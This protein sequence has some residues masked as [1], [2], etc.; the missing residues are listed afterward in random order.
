[1]IRKNTFPTGTAFKTFSDYNYAA[2]PIA[3][4]TTTVPL[5]SK[6]KA[7][8]FYGSLA[9]GLDKQVGTFGGAGG[10]SLIGTPLSFEFQ[11]SVAAGGVILAN[12]VVNLFY[13]VLDPRV[14]T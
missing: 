3:G 10:G 13:G 4:T 7:V 12:L 14:R 8:P 9:Y 5:S 1:M 6:G 2:Y 11:G